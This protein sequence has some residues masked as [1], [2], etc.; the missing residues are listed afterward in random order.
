[1]KSYSTIGLILLALV[2]FLFVSCSPDSSTPNIKYVDITDAKALVI[3]P[4]TQNMRS[5]NSSE[6]RFCKITEDGNITEVIAKDENGKNC[7][8]VPNYVFNAGDYMIICLNGS[9]FLVSRKTGTTYDMSSVGTPSIMRNN[10]G[11]DRQGRQSVFTDDNNNI[12]FTMNGR[13]AKIDVSNVNQ[14]TF[15]YITPDL[16]CINESDEFAVDKQG[17]VIFSSDSPNTVS[18]AGSS[19]YIRKTNGSIEKISPLQVS[20]T[21]TGYDGFIYLQINESYEHGY[22][23]DSK[24]LKKVSVDETFTISYTDCNQTGLT[25]WYSGGYNWIYMKDKIIATGYS[26][27]GFLVTSIMYDSSKSNYFNTF[28]SIKQSNVEEIVA[29]SEYCFASLSDDTIIKLN[30]ADGTYT[31]ILDKGIYD[32]CK[33]VSA[34]D[35][36][37]SFSGVRYSDGKRI[38]GTI[39]V[40]TRAVSIVN[41]S[42]SNDIIVLQKL[43]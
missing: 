18:L 37:V 5:T 20:M 25:S 15:E 8:I 33:I 10:L 7:T 42:L 6:N 19:L 32:V 21:F 24:M 28:T 40:D 34:S 16:Y 1:M 13:V 11:Y 12:Y 29:G 9:S 38:L 35:N 26:D 43:N 39:D 31:P 27:S 3:V 36:R 4:T 14:I 41:D 2:L 30:P 22:S 23:L 17:N